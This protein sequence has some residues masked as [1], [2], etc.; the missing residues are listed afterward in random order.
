MTAK[1]QW[2]NG[3]SPAARASE[4]PLPPAALRREQAA[5]YCGLPLRTWDR[6][7]ASGLAPQPIRVGRIPLWRVADLD[8]WLAAGAPPA[9]QMNNN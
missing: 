9:S 2:T 1:S 4:L 7:V 8:E 3:E 6:A 5:A